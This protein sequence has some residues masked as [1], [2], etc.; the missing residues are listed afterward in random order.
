MI[1]SENESAAKDRM[2]ML[3][4]GIALLWGLAAPARAVQ[5]VTSCGPVTGDVQLAAD[6][7]TTGY[8]C[9]DVKAD[10]ITI[11]G[12]GHSIT[13]GTLAVSILDHSHVTVMKI[14]TNQAVQIYGENAD[15]NMVR[16]S[17]IGKVAIYMG[18]DNHVENNFLTRLTVFDLNNQPAQRETIVGNYI[19]GTLTYDSEKLVQIRTGTDG[20]TAADGT[21]NCVSGGHLFA[22]NYLQGDV[23]PV[24]TTTTTNTCSGLLFCTPTTTTTTTPSTIEPHLL[25][26]ACG[27]DSTFSGNT[28]V[29]PNLVTGIVMRDEADR[30]LIENNTVRVGQGNQ[31]ALT[32]MSG[33]TGYHH[34]RD[35][36]FS[37]NTFRA[38][39]GRA[40]YLEAA[41]PRGNTFFNNVFASLSGSTET[42]RVVDGTG[43]TYLFD[44]NT[45]YNG[46]TGALVVFRNLG[47]GSMRFQSNI[48]AGQGNAI[49]GFDQPQGIEPSYVGLANDFYIPGLT[50]QVLNGWKSATGQD[51]NSVVG[52]PAFV[53][54]STGDFHI[55]A[56]SA[57][58]G[59]GQN[60][61][62]AGAY[63]Y[64]STAGT[65]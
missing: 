21:P 8:T 19:K 30:N 40:S 47:L 45:F 26:I 60:G 63:P 2:W 52:N 13:A 56:G 35:N 5:L 34:P 29:S 46:G 15:F 41:A 27:S 9:L 64:C 55:T 10:G 31:G 6:L 58:R 11:D 14:G 49:Y 50:T 39:S 33:I 62:D 1:G 48:I 57:A 3:A 65:C 38:D 16:D 20:T 53:S 4:I 42:L 22:D 36:T 24:T 59:V 61:T 25:W 51:L 43:V 12:A 54:P 28:L 44:H 32:I 18:D 7:V 23:A 17:Y 37:G